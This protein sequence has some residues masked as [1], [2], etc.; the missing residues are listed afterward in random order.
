[1]GVAQ[2][3]WTKRPRVLLMSINGTEVCTHVSL[4]NSS[5][6]HPNT[7]YHTQLTAGVPR[8]PSILNESKGLVV[9]APGEFVHVNAQF[10]LGNSNN[11]TKDFHAL[12]ALQSLTIPFAPCDPPPAPSPA[13]KMKLKPD[14]QPNSGLALTVRFEQDALLAYYADA[15]TKGDEAH[16]ESHFGKERALIMRKM[17]EL[18]LQEGRAM[19]EEAEAAGN[20]DEM[21]ERFR[22]AGLDDAAELVQAWSAESG[23]SCAHVR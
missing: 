13:T 20:A 14:V 8:P 22:L 11:I 21:L 16:M 10:R 4:A 3:P 9:L 6:H 5:Y 15:I 12:A 7:P 1:M 18:M 23:G 2:D 17:E 19:W